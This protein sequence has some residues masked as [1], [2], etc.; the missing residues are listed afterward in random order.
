MLRNVINKIENKGKVSTLALYL[1]CGSSGTFMSR[2]SKYMK[3]MGKIHSTERSNSFMHPFCKHLLSSYYVSGTITGSRD[4]AV[5]RKTLVVDT[6]LP[7]SWLLFSQS[8]F[9]TPTLKRL[10]ANHTWCPY[11]LALQRVRIMVLFIW[12]FYCAQ[13]RVSVCVGAGIYMYVCVCVCEIHEQW[14]SYIGVKQ[15]QALES[16]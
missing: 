8:F 4:T 1:C 11:K 14:G 16:E 5:K 15:K 2:S 3:K 13:H 6:L 10:C 9:L 12:L 7:R